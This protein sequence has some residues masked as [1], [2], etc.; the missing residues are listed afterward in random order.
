[1]IGLI[2]VWSKRERDEVKDNILWWGKEWKFFICHKMGKSIF[3]K[4]EIWS[5]PDFKH[6]VI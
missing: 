6:Y 5:I 4:I 2:E 3:S 1:M